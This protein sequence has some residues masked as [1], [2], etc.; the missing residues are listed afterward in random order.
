M[1]TTIGSS[2]VAFKASMKLPALSSASLTISQVRQAFSNLKESSAAGLTVSAGVL[3]AIISSFNS[4]TNDIPFASSAHAAELP[5]ESEDITARVVKNRYFD[6]ERAK[7]AFVD[8]YDGRGVQPTDKEPKLQYE[9]YWRELAQ[10]LDWQS[11][12]IHAD[13]L[14]WLEGQPKAEELKKEADLMR[15]HSWWEHLFIDSLE[16]S[17]LW[18]PKHWAGDWGQWTAEGCEQVSK[19]NG[20]TGDCKIPDWRSDEQKA[21]HRKEW[22]YH[23][24]AIRQDVEAMKEIGLPVPSEIAR[25]YKRLVD[26][27]A[28]E[29]QG[30]FSSLLD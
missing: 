24:Q 5:L 21:A 17:L 27:G 3:F 1:M 15:L 13:A 30:F 10:T 8:A 2:I 22:T 9:S 6:F 18:G 16:A 7:N 20:L 28:I 12:N 25:E 4:L 23:V 11:K 14:S 29:G 19:W 26:L